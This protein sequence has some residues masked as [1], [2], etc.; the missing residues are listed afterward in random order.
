MRQPINKSTKFASNLVI[1]FNLVAACMRNANLFTLQYIFSH[2]LQAK[3]TNSW[4]LSAFYACVLW[5]ERVKAEVLI[6]PGEYPRNKTN[7]KQQMYKKVDGLTQSKLQCERE[8][9]RAQRFGIS[10]R[11]LGAWS[12]LC[13]VGAVP[14]CADSSVEKSRCRLFGASL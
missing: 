6:F 7:N 3:I 8:G 5:L 2:F 11:S 12:A 9:C 10:R 1:K 13:R 14:H 4:S